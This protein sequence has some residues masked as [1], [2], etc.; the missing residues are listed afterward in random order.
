MSTEPL[1]A[2]LIALES[3]PHQRRMT[4]S[5]GPSLG[6]STIRL[7]KWNR[8]GTMP[9]KPALPTIAD[10]VLPSP[11]PTRCLPINKSTLTPSPPWENGHGSNHTLIRHQQWQGNMQN[12][13]LHGTGAVLFE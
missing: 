2:F 5:L 3:C 13:H 10:L 7:E 1:A 4:T 8:L 9:C 12:A 11:C 6:G